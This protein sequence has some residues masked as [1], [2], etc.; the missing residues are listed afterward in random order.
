M[1]G[2]RPVPP[3]DSAATLAMAAASI[4]KGS[5]SFA[6]AARLFDRPTRESAILLYAWCRHCDDVVDG[7][8]HGHATERGAAS[9]AAGAR[10]AAL[11][12]STRA[13]LVPGARPEEP[14]FAALAEVVRRAEI[15]PGYPLAHLDGFRM[16]VEERRYRGFAD[17]LD[18]CYH[19]A[20]VVGVMMAHVMGVRDPVT[21]DRA[22]DL[23][24]AFQLTNMAR[25][26]VDDA[27]VGRVY[28]P[29][30]WLTQEGL[31]DAGLADLVHRAALARIAAR[32]VDSA[33]PYYASARIGID[34]LPP[35][36]SWAIATALGI[37]RAIGTEVKRR[38]PRAWDRRVSTSAAAKLG[39]VLR[40]A[41][42]LARRRPDVRPER[43][44]LWTRPA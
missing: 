24:I 26:L 6:A 4:A 39:H 38:G 43:P 19:V 42:R 12:A 28:V 40:G 37:Y 16:D 21:L 30:E 35:R 9:G 3:E 23:G 8:D 41:G 44:G 5:R 20:G 14:P 33:E 22:C 7:Q 36:S 18:Y 2:S 27:R 15:P 10:L 13:A 34:A 1:P 11:Q 29:E 31:A 32:L 25:D 17:T